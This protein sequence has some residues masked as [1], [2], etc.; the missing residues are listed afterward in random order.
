MNHTVFP[1]LRL[2][3]NESSIDEWL[4]DIDVNEVYSWIECEQGRNFILDLIASGHKQ[5]FDFGIFALR[6]CI[7]DEDFFLRAADI[8]RLKGNPWDGTLSTLV[9]YSGYWHSDLSDIAF[10][11]LCGIGIERTLMIAAVSLTKYEIS[12]DIV[13]YIQ[14]SYLNE[15]TLENMNDVYLDLLAR[16][17]FDGLPQYSLANFTEGEIEELSIG[18]DP[19]FFWSDDNTFRVLRGLLIGT[20]L[21]SDSMSIVERLYPGE[22][23]HVYDTVNFIRMSFLKSK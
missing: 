3:C 2:L 4:N 15:L 9:L 18:D 13:S 11:C 8:L 22:D 1:N 21:R 10:R 23:T 5:L 7:F 6:E 12:K 16:R 14:R 19:R 20:A 17:P